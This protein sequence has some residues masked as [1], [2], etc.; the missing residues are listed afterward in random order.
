MPPRL[1]V[2]LTGGIASGKSA[3]AARF[4]ELGVPV[5]DADVAARR[6]VEPGSV[7]LAQVVQQFGP[8]LLTAD[9]RL[10][11]SALRSA[12][13]ADAAA[14]KTVNAILHPLIRDSME[15]EVAQAAG[16][17]VVLAIPLLVESGA[18]HD[19]VARVLVIDVNENT[20][21]KRL[22]ARDGTSLAQ[23]RAIL[24]AQASRAARL[25][26]A[27]DVIEN[28]GTLS[29]LRDAV[30]VLHAKYLQIAK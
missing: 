23:A 19:R 5:I 13:F 11:R 17:Y 10:D 21:I 16:P 25:A 20:Q 1:R 14:R 4:T 26:A 29:D 8:W 27:D 24:N 9:G 18:P 2:G 22:L 6:V 7:G 15:S 30:D 28:T 3:A 12:I